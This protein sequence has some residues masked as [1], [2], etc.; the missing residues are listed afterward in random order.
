MNKQLNELKENSNKQLN[1]NA[2]RKTVL[3][4]KEEFN[5]NIEILKNQIESLE[6]KSSI[7]QAKNS[8]ENLL[9]EQNK[10]E[11]DYQNLKVK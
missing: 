10:V 2:G 11:I 6:M 9:V 8:V 5:K 7:S 1:D 3:D 4:M